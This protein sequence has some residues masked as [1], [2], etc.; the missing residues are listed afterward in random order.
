[1]YLLELQQRNNTK[2]SGSSDIGNV[3]YVCPTYYCELEIA[4]NEN[5]FIHE[6]DFLKFVDSPI[7]YDRLKKS[8]KAFVLS[9]IEVYNNP[10]VLE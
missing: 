8:I 3:S 2:A 1:M 4:S 5:V 6:E 9:A 10:I 7:A